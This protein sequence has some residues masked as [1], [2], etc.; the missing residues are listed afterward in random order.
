MAEPQTYDPINNLLID[1]GT[2]LNEI[3]EKHKLLKDRTLLIGE[4]LIS[5]KEESEKQFSEFKK[6]LYQLELE[7]KEIKRLN[8]RIVNEMENLARKPELEILGRQMKMFEPL[9]FVRME[10]LSQLIRE[11]ISKLR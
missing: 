11:E 2:R 7:I 1:F 3:E 6:Q 4:N 8:K 5:T 9:K 10:E